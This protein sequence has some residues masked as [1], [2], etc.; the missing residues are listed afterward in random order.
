MSWRRPL[1]PVARRDVPALTESRLRCVTENYVRADTITAWRAVRAGISPPP[2]L[3]FRHC[4]RRSVGTPSSTVSSRHSRRGRP[5]GL[6]C[7]EPAVELHPT[8]VA[9]AGPAAGPRELRGLRRSLA[10]GQAPHRERS[11]STCANELFL[12]WDT[13]AND[14]VGILR[15]EAGRDPYDKRLSD[16]IGELSTRTFSS[17][18]GCPCTSREQLTIRL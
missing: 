6:L 3:S 15:A 17:T 13:I 9:R 11:S 12:D 8:C 10:P 7:A 14:C 1:R 5:S 18:E 2:S 16:L 4:R